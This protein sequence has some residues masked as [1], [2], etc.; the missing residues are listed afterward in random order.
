[1]NCST[2]L[3][4]LLLAHVS[5]VVC[6][7]PQRVGGGFSCNCTSSFGGATCTDFVPCSS[8]PCLFDSICINEGSSYRCEAR[9]TPDSS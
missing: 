4:S 8:A 7:S 1:M 6:G 9:V 3:T 2:F 5:D